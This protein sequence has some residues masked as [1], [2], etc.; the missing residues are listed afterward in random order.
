[1]ATLTDI[2]AVIN[3]MIAHGDLG[4]HICF[5]GGSMPYIYHG[6]E[7]GREHSDIDVLVDEECMDYV[8]KL[9][10]EVGIYRQERDSLSLGLDRDYGLKVFIDGVY[11]EFEPMMI[12]DGYLSRASFSP[13]KKVAGIEVTPFLE[14]EDIMVPVTIDGIQTLTESMELI[15]ASK[16]KYGRKKDIDDI[17]FI[18]GKGI[19]LEKYGRVVTY[20][21][22]TVPDI[23]PYEELRNR[24]LK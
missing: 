12:K 3:K 13:D 15:R 21:R 22:E 18:D 2:K 24:T 14:I 11:V 4:Q 9:L 8:R 20:L 1:M 7:S 16:A 23:A 17:A 5:F 10:K 6:K 19:D